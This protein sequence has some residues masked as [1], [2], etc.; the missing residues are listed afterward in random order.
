[1]NE[2]VLLDNIY[3]FISR[4]FQKESNLFTLYFQD[5]VNFFSILNKE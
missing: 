4:I 1:M 3:K 5:I 2:A